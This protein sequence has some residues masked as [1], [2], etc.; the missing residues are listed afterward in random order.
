MTATVR[1]AAARW[2]RAG[3]IGALERVGIG[4]GDVVFVH[5]GLEALGPRAAG[6]AAASPAG[7]TLYDALRAVVGPRGTIL[8]P[9]YSFS[10]CRG[11]T[12]D[13]RATPAAAGPWCPSRDFAEHVRRHADAVRSRDPIHSVAG[14]GPLA[15]DLLRDVPPTCFGT[16]SV[17]GRLRAAGGKI[18]LVGL[19]LEE[20]TFRHHVE[21]LVGVPFRFRK[22]FTGRIR[23]GEEEY[24]IGWIFYV[25]ILA[26]AAAPDGARLEAAA[27][28]DGVCRAAPV[29]RGEVLAVGTQAFFDLAARRLRADPW[30]T[31]RGPAGDPL[32]LDAARVAVPA[33]RAALEPGA[34]MAR[35]LDALWPLPRDIVS[36]GYDAALAAL[37]EQVPMTVHEYPT[38]TEC[39]SWL[40][41]EKWT[42]REARLERLDGERLFSYADHPLHVV[43]YSLPFEGVVSREELL[44]HLH[45]HPT[46]PDAIPF[47]FRYYEREWGLC[48][49][50]VQRERLT[51]AA[52]RV[53]IRTEFSY[54]T[55]KVGEV[56]AP[57]A[58]DE[59][60]V[61]CAHLCHPAQANDDLT[62]VVVGI[63]V[64]RA[65]LA[66]PERRWTH[67]LLVVPE[68]IGSLA[69]LSR[70]A[71]LLPRLRGGLFLEM[72]GRDRP[73]ALQHSFA[74]DTAVDECFAEA[75]RAHEPAGWTSPFR[76]LPGNDERQFNAPGVRVPMLLL[77][78]V[79][80]PGAPSAPYAEYHS[81]HDVPALV[82]AARLAESRDLVLAMLDRWERADTPR[83]RVP[84]EP[85]CSRFGVHVDPYA[86]PEGNRALF[87]VVFRMDGT[88]TVERIAR[89][90]GVG[91]A[92]VRRVVAELRRA[93]VAA[94]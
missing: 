7:A 76:T 94:P 37:A 25:R 40:V 54:G 63:D 51:D 24:R 19:P 73:H 23:D 47:V 27:R 49:S 21:E 34:S 86:D 87:D 38:G 52:Y 58:R 68:T 81:S 79:L 2:S 78:R 71:D 85:F 93:G 1:P 92:S 66:R 5:A 90:C 55:L 15:A 48:C 62:G 30:D 9:T 57:G 26:D 33:P 18:C 91:V 29:G 64:M 83:L 17:H 74:G 42:C 32:A 16:E 72:L 12:F 3:L 59:G 80:P 89:E 82:P 6:D 13:V 53:V 69:F 39:W 56:V 45:V 20:A 14:V 28:D 10:F 31:A 65:L 88:R 60:L 41:P 35:M 11:E 4:T 70:R 46:L 84:G 43:S 36:D 77:A 75:L 50:Q 61:L 44:G 22:L 8:A 67:R